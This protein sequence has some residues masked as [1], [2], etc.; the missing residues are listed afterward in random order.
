MISVFFDPIYFN[1]KIKV[2]ESLFFYYASSTK[3][4]LN[5]MNRSYLTPYP[6]KNISDF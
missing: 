6:N 1:E 5:K 3:I 2:V 4:K